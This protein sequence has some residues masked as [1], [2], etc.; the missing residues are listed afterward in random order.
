MLLYRIARILVYA[1]LLVRA[2]IEIHTHCKARQA[3]KGRSPR[4][5]VD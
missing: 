3:E 1:A 5:S 4:E 2:W